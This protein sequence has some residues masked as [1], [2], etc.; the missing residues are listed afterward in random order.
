MKTIGRVIAV[1]RCEQSVKVEI[2]IRSRGYDPVPLICVIHVAVKD[3]HSYWIGRR[4]RLG[5]TP[6]PNRGG[7]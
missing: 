6:M 7:A 2:R 4:V 5:A 3:A 1:E